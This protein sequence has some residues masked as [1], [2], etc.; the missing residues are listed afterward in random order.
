M[1]RIPL[2]DIT[3]YY[4]WRGNPAGPVVV[5]VNGLLTD[6]SS[7]EGHLPH[8][9]ERY[10]CLIYDCRGQGQA[11]K[12]DEVYAT[13]LHTADL[14]ALL[15]ALAVPRAAI[16]GL[17]HGGAAALGYAAQYPDRVSALVVSGVHAHVSAILRAK[18]GSWVAAMEAGGSPLRFDV[19]TPWVWGAEFLEAHYEALLPYREKGANLPTAPAANLIRGA[20]DH[21]VRVLLP[22]I[23]APTLVV[24]GEDDLLTPPKMARAIA[25]AV[26]H[27]ELLVAPDLG[28]AAALEDV[29]GFCRIALDFLARNAAGGS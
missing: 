19:A 6:C 12:P 20:M 7:W 14:A 13:R 1:P 9:V 21:D 23:T 28:H 3:L 15:D 10:H 8:F 4:E 2:G 18:L 27:G 25:E 16:V 22:G 17:S 24:V 5:F 29:P 11:D 26:P